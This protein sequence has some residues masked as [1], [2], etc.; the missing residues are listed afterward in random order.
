[1]ATCQNAR[2]RHEDVPASPVDVS[3]QAQLPKENTVM[4]VKF[5]NWCVQPRDAFKKVF[6]STVATASRYIDKHGRKRYQGTG[7]LKGTQEYTPKF[8]AAVVATIPSLKAMRQEY[9]ANLKPGDLCDVIASL[10]Y[11][12]NWDDANL[13]DAFAYVRNSKLLAIPGQFRRIVPNAL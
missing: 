7:A 2:G 13:T 5:G 8:A 10:E 12:D 6:R 11:A 9:S 4:V 3:F 1:M